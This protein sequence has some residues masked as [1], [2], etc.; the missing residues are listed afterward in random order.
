MLETIVFPYTLL[1]DKE[2]VTVTNCTPWVPQVATI[3]RGVNGTTATTH[4]TGALIDV[5]PSALFAF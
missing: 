1:I 3:T 2:Q 4:A 5:A